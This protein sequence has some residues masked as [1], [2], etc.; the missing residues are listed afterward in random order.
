MPLSFTTSFCNSF[1]VHLTN[2]FYI[3]N[4]FNIVPLI[5]KNLHCS[6]T[7]KNVDIERGSPLSKYEYISVSE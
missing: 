4:I 6:Y 3:E 7:E 2:I 1:L 5:L